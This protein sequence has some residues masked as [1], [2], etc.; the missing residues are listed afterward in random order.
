MSNYRDYYVRDIFTICSTLKKQRSCPSLL[1]HFRCQYCGRNCSTASDQCLACESSAQKEQIAAMLYKNDND[2]T[3]PDIK[4]PPESLLSHRDSTNTHDNTISM[5]RSQSCATIGAASSTDTSI[6]SSRNSLLSDINMWL[7]RMCNHSNAKTTIECIICKN[8]KTDI[9]TNDTNN[10]NNNNTT[11]DDSNNNKRNTCENGFEC[12]NN[13]AASVTRDDGDKKTQY[14]RSCS[15]TPP[16]VPSRRDQRLSLSNADEKILSS[17]TK[18]SFIG[19]SDSVLSTFCP[20]STQKESNWTCDRCSYADNSSATS[21]CDV[22][23]AT[24][25][26]CSTIIVDKDTVRYTPPKRRTNTETLLS[27][28]ADPLRQ[29]LEEDFQFLP[30]EQH[31]SREEWRCKKC[32]LLN[33]DEVNICEACGGSK[34]RSLTSTPEATL[35]HGEFWICPRCTLKNALKEGHCVVCKTTRNSEMSESMKY[36]TDTG[37]YT[38][39]SLPKYKNHDP[40]MISCRPK[41]TR[42]V[43]GDKRN[44]GE[45]QSANA[46]LSREKR[47]WVCDECTYENS[48]KSPCC[49]ICQSARSIFGDGLLPSAKDTFSKRLSD[50]DNASIVIQTKQQSELME[51]LRQNEE[52]EALIR[53]QQIVQYCKEVMRCFS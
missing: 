53:W 34:I 33:S 49:E 42:S 52:E 48:V 44:H 1:H 3:K 43:V 15:F 6:G 40:L 38:V 50:S 16:C 8:T 17:A 45:N 39:S 26:E 27:P 22:C 41:L 5:R 31:R 20:D 7:C 24:A 11:D 25:S 13:N 12:V 10:N 30:M 18:F 19:T 37:K 36:N 2:K 23:D 47:R 29:T 46:N 35:K 14:R 9:R 28:P 21:R 51:Q 4:D 32:T